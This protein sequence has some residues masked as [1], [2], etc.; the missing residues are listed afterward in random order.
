[1]ARLKT[2]TIYSDPSHGWAKVPIKILKELGIADKISRYS[3]KRGDMAY[4]EED[5]DMGIYIDKLKEQGFEPSFKEHHTD[6]SSRIRN[7]IPYTQE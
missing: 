7:Y 4:L 3:Y 2:I 6:R 1:M 5:L